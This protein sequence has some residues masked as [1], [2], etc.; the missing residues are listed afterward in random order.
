MAILH[1][2]LTVCLA[3]TLLVGVS[4]HLVPCGNPDPMGIQAADMSDG[5]STSAPC[6]DHR[7]PNCVGHLGCVVVPAIPVSATSVAVDFIGARLDYEVAPQ[8]LPGISVEPELSPPIL[9]A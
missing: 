6:S 1:R 9:A 8:A 3:L 4:T 7:M 2:L 5:C